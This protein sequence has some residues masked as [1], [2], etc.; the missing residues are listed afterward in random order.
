MYTSTHVSTPRLWSVG[1][2]SEQKKITK[3]AILPVLPEP[4]TAMS[5]VHRASSRAKHRTQY[6]WL[7]SSGA[8]QSLP[9]NTCAKNKT[10]CADVRGLKS[11]RRGSPQCGVTS[12]AGD[13][14]DIISSSCF[15]CPP[16][17]L[18]TD[19][20]VFGFLAFLCAPSFSTSS[21]L[22]FSSSCRRDLVR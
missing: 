15:S 2:E 3:V 7:T 19:V 6:V 12:S 18:R 4:I 9:G 5:W 22:A 20:R 1:S 14:T 10:P 13:A 17:G 11:V 16:L 8:L 21:L